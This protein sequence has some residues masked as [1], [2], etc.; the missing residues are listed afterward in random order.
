MAA[1]TTTPGG[2]RPPKERSDVT[3]HATRLS[4]PPTWASARNCAAVT[5]ETAKV[6]LV[7]NTKY[8]RSEDWAIDSASPQ[9][10]TTRIGGRRRNVPSSASLGRSA[11][12]AGEATG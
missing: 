8:A 10:N 2:R 3:P 12:C 9:P 6:S 5:T 4:V 7:Y 11:A 1:L